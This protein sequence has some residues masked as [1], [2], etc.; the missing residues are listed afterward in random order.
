MGDAMNMLQPPQLLT[1]AHVRGGFSCGHV[2]LDAWLQQRAQPNQA[3]GASRTYVVATARGEPFPMEPL[4]LML[5]LSPLTVR[6]LPP[7]A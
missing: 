7:S 1:T 5:A 6:R 3:S 4:M 2:V